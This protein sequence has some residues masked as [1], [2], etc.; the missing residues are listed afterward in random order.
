MKLFRIRG[1]DVVWNALLAPFILKEKLTRW[2]KCAKMHQNVQISR[3]SS[4]CS[5]QHVHL[6][7]SETSGVLMLSLSKLSAGTVWWA[8]S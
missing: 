4:L 8:A 6:A 7:I 5:S 1:L 3:S 2:Q